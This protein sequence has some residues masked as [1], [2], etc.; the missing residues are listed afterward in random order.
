MYNF[1]INYYYFRECYIGFGL[2]KIINYFYFLNSLIFVFLV[3]FR[4]RDFSVVIKDFIVTN[5]I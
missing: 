2:Y 3:E 5:G 1:L 4:K